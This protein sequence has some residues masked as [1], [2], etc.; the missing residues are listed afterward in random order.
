MLHVAI[1]MSDYMKPSNHCPK[2]M[3][4][5]YHQTPCS[6]QR[7]P[8]MASD[9]KCTLDELAFLLAFSLKILHSRRPG[10]YKA[11]M[12]LVCLKCLFLALVLIKFLYRICVFLR[13]LFREYLF[14]AIPSV[15]TNPKIKNK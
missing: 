7:R 8:S 1:V 4:Y 2:L 9:L 13:T 5:V 11:A 3:S 12:P 10:V 14:V 6:S 15:A